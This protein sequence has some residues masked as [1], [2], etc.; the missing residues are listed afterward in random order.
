MNSGDAPQKPRCALARFFP[1][2]LD[3]EKVKADGW[4]HDRILVIS[5][6]DPLLRRI[7]S[8][9]IESI[10]NRLYGRWRARG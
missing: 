8:Q 5:A 6:D 7:E 4:N 9:V 3:I 2:Q 10:G 1:D